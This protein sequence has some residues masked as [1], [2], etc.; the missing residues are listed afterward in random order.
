MNVAVFSAPSYEAVQKVFAEA[1]GQLGEILSAF[2]F[3]DKQSVSS[4]DDLEFKAES[5]SLTL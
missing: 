3:W 1:K 4:F 2:E 5:Y